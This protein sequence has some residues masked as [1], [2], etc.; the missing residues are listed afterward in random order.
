MLWKALRDFI[1]AK[2]FWLYLIITTSLLTVLIEILSLFYRINDFFPYFFLIPMFLVA[3]VFP[4]KGVVFTFAS[5]WIYILLVFIYGTLSVRIIAVHMAWFFTY[6]TLGVVISFHLE[7]SRAR[8]EQAEHLHTQAC[9]QIEQN[10][11][12]F[13]II[14]DEIRNPLQ[15]IMLDSDTITSPTEKENI[16]KQVQTIDNILRRMDTNSLESK[17]IRSYLQKHY[18]FDKEQ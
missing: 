12:Q 5:G 14:N 2:S 9:Q 18:N 10:I 6:I 3:F 17:K 8:I 16:L 13:E 4:K 11:Q 15:A 7:N 1:T